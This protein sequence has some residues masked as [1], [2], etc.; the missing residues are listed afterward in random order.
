MVRRCLDEYAAKC[1]QD[2][3]IDNYEKEICES[4]QYTSNTR[5]DAEN[6]GGSADE[7]E[8]NIKDGLS[9]TILKEKPNVRFSDVAGCEDSKRV[10]KEA[11]MMPQLMPAHIRKNM[12][13]WKGILLYGPPGTGK[14]MMAKALAGES[15]ATFFSVKASDLISKWQ[16]QS[17][18][19][20]KQLFILA[21]E[22]RPAII[23]FDEVDGLASK[24]SEDDTDSTRR[25]KTELFAQMDGLGNNGTRDISVI[26]TTNV[27]WLLDEAIRRRFQN[28][29]VHYRRFLLRERIK[30]IDEK[31][32]I[33][34]NLLGALHIFR[35]AWAEVKMET[36][37]NCFRHAKFVI[38]T[39]VSGPSPLDSTKWLN[40]LLLPCSPKDPLAIRMTLAQVK[41]RNKVIARPINK[42][43]LYL[44]KKYVK[45]LKF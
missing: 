11:V 9:S 12:D 2:E 43:S 40:D 13:P 14:T 33:L 23:F 5:L 10:F 31:K 6:Y 19:A 16:G 34:I 22:N 45:C 29:K 21:S 41:D 39:E 36:I 4:E 8:K 37:A 1:A 20:I 44:K 3:E 26:A 7:D 30:A 25:I 17:E 32:D 38:N 15:N 18:K 24:R 35:R 28:L 42:A 27:P